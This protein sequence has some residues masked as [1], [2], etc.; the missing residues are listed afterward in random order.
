MV[1]KTHN[2]WLCYLH[3]KGKVNATKKH[4]FLFINNNGPLNPALLIT[5]NFVQFEMAGSAMKYDLSKSTRLT[6]FRMKRGY[7]ENTAVNGG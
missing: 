5:K 4:T 6:F 2:C 7:R 3:K 1:S